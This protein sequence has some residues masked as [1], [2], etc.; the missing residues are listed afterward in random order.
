MT[1]ALE[2]GV[3]LMVLLGLIKGRNTV[4]KLLAFSWVSLKICVITWALLGAVP[5]GTTA[6]SPPCNLASASGK[7][8]YSPCVSIMAKPCKRSTAKNW[9]H[10]T[11]GATGLSVDRLMVPFTR[12]STTKLR[13]VREA[14]ARAT[15]SISALTKL[16]V[17]GALAR[18][19]CA[20]RWGVVASNA[21]SAKRLSACRLN[22]NMVIPIAIPLYF[23]AVGPAHRANWPVPPRCQC[24]L[25]PVL[26]S[27]NLGLATRLAHS[28]AAR[29]SKC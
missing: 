6:T 19:V 3:T 9:F 28:S 2:P 7:I 12:G 21:L 16:S 25:G 22:F 27:A 13:L 14:K 4:T 23:L 1:K 8:L 11:S 10:A 26:Q 29:R 5:A 17:M 15:D 20:S 18:L 24:L